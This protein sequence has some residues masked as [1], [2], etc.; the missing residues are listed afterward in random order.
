[1]CLINNKQSKMYLL[2][3]V[4]IRSST[5]RGLL[6][7]QKVE[8]FIILKK[9]KLFGNPIGKKFKSRIVVIFTNLFVHSSNQIISCVMTDSLDSSSWTFLRPSLKAL[10]HLRTLLPLMVMW[11]Y[12]S[13][14]SRLI[15]AAETFLAVKK[16]ISYCISQSAV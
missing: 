12:T 3:R 15:S 11:P 14:I 7:S 6:C 13:L 10:T 16:Q 1:M 8:T 9:E 5:N 2:I 4:K